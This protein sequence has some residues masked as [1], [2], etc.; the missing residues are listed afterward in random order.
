MIP[1][2]EIEIKFRVEN[3]RALNQRLRQAGFR[4]MTPRTHEMNTLYDLPGQP[5]RKRGELLR[6]RKYGQKWTLTHKAQGKAGRHKSRVENETQL[7]DGRRMEIILLALGFAPT[8][9]YEKFRAE[10]SDGKGHVVV[11]QTPIGNFCEIEG[12]ARWIDQTARHLRVL[13]ANYITDTYA[14]LFLRWKKLT[15]SS[16]GEMTFSSVAASTNR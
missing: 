9:R 13:Q 16:A 10:W 3:L 15:I 2:K 8:F 7:A 5:L 4:V 6:L 1:H 12:P 11:D 14:A